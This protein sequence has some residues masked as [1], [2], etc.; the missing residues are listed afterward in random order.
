MDL[1]RARP[2]AHFRAGAAGGLCIL[3]DKLGC[4][5]EWAQPFTVRPLT[6][7]GKPALSIEVYGQPGLTERV[8]LVG[9]PGA[10]RFDYRSRGLHIS[11]VWGG[12][13]TPSSAVVDLYDVSYRGLPICGPGRYTL[14]AE[15]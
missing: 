2:I 7:A 15:Q 9:E 14:P 13:L 12:R 4:M 5:G 6:A 8:V 10:E 3:P 1:P 11:G